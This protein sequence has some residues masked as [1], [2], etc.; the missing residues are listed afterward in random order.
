MKLFYLIGTDRYHQDVA[1]Q[2]ILKGIDVPFVVANQFDARGQ[3]MTQV[4]NYEALTDPAF[5]QKANVDASVVLSE[6]LI[7]Q[8]KDCENEFLT[9]S[10]RFTFFNISVR[11]RKQI[12]YDMLI[13]WYEF[14]QKNPVDVIF[15]G[16]TPHGN[17]DNVLYTVAQKLGIRAIYLERTG[18]NDKVFL[19]DNFRNMPR[20]PS[21]Y[22]RDK[23][24]DELIAIFGKEVYQEIFATSYWIKGFSGAPKKQLKFSDTKFVKGFKGLL[25]FLD[26]REYGKRQTPSVFSYNYSL[27]NNTLL[28]MEQLRK[29]RDRK[30][31]RYYQSLSVTGDFTQKYVFFP[32]QFQPERTSIPLGGVFDDQILAIQ[33]LSKAIPRDWK[34]YVKE[35]HRQLKYPR[36]NTRHYRDIKFYDRIKAID[37]VVFVDIEQNT[38]DLIQHAQVTTTLTG[39]V[40]WESMVAGKAC[41][42]FGFPWYLGCRGCYRVSSVESCRE[43][44]NAILN[45]NKED[46]E[47]DLIRF[48]IYYQDRWITASNSD[49]FVAQSGRD[50]AQLVQNLADALADLAHKTSEELVAAK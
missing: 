4:L 32:L 33:I 29:I 37:K 39:S 46:V 12:Y 3:G 14:L 16:A 50:Y 30:L 17:W 40:G 8:F 23:T 15:T 2:L 22:L 47:K 45:H 34:I 7:L 9:N 5:Y 24:K 19:V 21:D 20:V 25:R 18:I 48:L 43:A 36:I 35:H 11:K 13:F 10:D 27:N 41:M 28:L 44:I 38:Q 6:D 26:V 1:Q 49:H 42:V 31:Y